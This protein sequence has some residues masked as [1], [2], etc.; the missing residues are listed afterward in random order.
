M[1]PAQ[2]IVRIAVTLAAV[3]LAV[4]TVRWMWIRYEVEPWTRDGR[5]RADT[6]EVAADVTGLV[7][8]VDVRDNSPVKKGQLLFVVDR[9]RYGL[10]LAQAEAAI[11]AQQAA[12]SQAEREARRNRVLGTLVARESSEQ[13]LSRVD[14]LRAA[15][16]QAEVNRDLARLNL[17]RTTVTASVDGTVANVQLRPGDYAVAGKPVMALIDSASLHVDGY[18]EET[19]LPYIHVGD[20][21]AVVVMGLSEPIEGHVQSIAGGIADR[22]RSAS[23]TLLP[24]VNPVFSWVRLA[25]RIPVRIAIDRAPA[26]MRLIAGRTA[27]VT[28]HPKGGPAE[29]NPS[30]WP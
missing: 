19:K 9:A 7:T 29:P 4:L 2:R 3:L 11:Q 17:S 25:Q 15:L 6:V 26:G 22:E 30:L 28:V 24:N 14:S 21:A 13:T 5:L 23:E 27:T 8:E 10:A 20:R 16:R 1:P 12:L 18:F